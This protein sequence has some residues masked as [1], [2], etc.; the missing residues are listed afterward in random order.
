MLT[1]P[2]NKLII[3]AF[4]W[5]FVGRLELDFVFHFLLFYVLSIL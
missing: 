3:V 4:V 1:N 5:C 2:R